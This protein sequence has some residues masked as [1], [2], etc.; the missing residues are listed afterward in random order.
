MIYFKM[1]REGES[2]WGEYNVTMLAVSWSL[3]KLGIDTC[4]L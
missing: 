3:L 4:C 2:G 1:R